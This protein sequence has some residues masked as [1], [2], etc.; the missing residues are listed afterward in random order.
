MASRTPQSSDVSTPVQILSIIFYAGFA[1]SVSIVAMNFFWPAG[2]VMGAIFAYQWGR[3]PTLNGGRDIV[4]DAPDFVAEV[5]LNSKKATEK[6]SG[7]ASFD[8]YRQEMLQRLEEEQKNFKAFLER[9]RDARDKEEFDQFME[10]RAANA[11]V[12]G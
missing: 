8:A 11:K 6:S 9:L 7:N 10:D 1:I 12:A 5:V 2:I 4:E 3:I